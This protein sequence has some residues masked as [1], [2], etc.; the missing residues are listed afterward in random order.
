MMA[1]T[2]YTLPG[3]IIVSALGALIV[4]LLLFRYGFGPY[5]DEEPEDSERR[6][7][8]VRVGH[9]AAALCFASAA[10]LAVAA[11]TARPLDGVAAPA[12]AVAPADGAQ[13]EQLTA[14]LQRLEE[15]LDRE[16]ARLDE[17]LAAPAASPPLASAP[18]PREAT[19]PARSGTPARAS[20]PPARE[21]PPPA[22]EALPPSRP[23]RPPAAAERPPAPRSGPA[24]SEGEAALPAEATVR[25]VRATVQGVRVDVETRPGRDQELVYTIRLL[26][27]GNQALTG[28]DVALHGSRPDGSSLHA[29]FEPAEPGVYR[30]RLAQSA[31]DARDL[32]LRV[33][34]QGRRFEL[35]LG[36]AVSW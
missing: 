8:I 30:G 34:G 20:T 5:E 23:S 6:L 27:A 1:L 29:A 7:L 22:R 15:R 9:G 24:T 3:I 36:Q 17:R 16:I 18:P 31:E 32:R 35:A 13:I 10:I 25:R 33:V 11:W 19:S 2:P 14:E 28:M 12:S 26:D 21:I 4:A